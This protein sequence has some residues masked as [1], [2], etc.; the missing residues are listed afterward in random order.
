MERDEWLGVGQAIAATAFFSMGTILVRLA[1]GLSPFEVT[2]LRML[3]AAPL[4]AGAARLAG[5]PVRLTSR[6][7]RRLVPIG[8]VAALHFLTFIASLYFTSVAHAV[9]L[10][11]TAPL[12]IA[13]LSRPMLGEPF[14]PRARLGGGIALVGLAILTGLG[15]RLSLRMIVGDLLALAAALTFA[16]YSILGRRERGRL[17]ILVYAAWVYFLAGLLVLPFGLGLFTRSV[18]AGALAAVAAMALFPMAL[19]HTLYNA[20][21]RRLHPS[22]P[23]LIATQEVTLAILLAWLLLAEV[24]SLPALAGAAVT[25]LGVLVVLR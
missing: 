11:Y 5:H 21:V 7:V 24:P 14:P 25:L 16:L 9:T 23:N 15:P 20:A 18:P 17:P 8:A 13:G 1:A 19:G 3:L 10:V 12:F 2:W 22:L 4:V 6:E